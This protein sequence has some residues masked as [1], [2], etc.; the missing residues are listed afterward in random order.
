MGLT[1]FFP[2]IAS[3]T[4]FTFPVGITG[5][6]T[7]AIYSINASGSIGN[8][9]VNPVNTYQPTVIDP[10]RVLQYYWSISSSGITGFNGSLSLLYQQADVLGTE[11]DYVAAWLQLPGTYWVKAPVGPATDNVDE[12]TN[13][14][15]FIFPPGTSNLIGDFTAG[16]D[17]AIPNQ[18]PTY[19]T[20]SSGNWS[21]STIWTPV[22]G[23]PP[24]P[25]GG[26]NGFNV[27]IQDSVATIT[28]FYDRTH[29]RS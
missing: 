7:P 13:Q 4:V 23:A 2:V 10:A 16:E 28:N 15:T 25:A 21:D 24:C 9:I 29:I 17:S 18:V 19:I 3:P 26:P 20:N 8:I 12:A 14:I 22:G 11:S 5:I 6:Y 27:I 1:K